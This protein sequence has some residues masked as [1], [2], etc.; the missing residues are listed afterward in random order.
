MVE[1][2]HD[3]FDPVRFLS[4]VNVENLIERNKARSENEVNQIKEP[5][6]MCNNHNTSG[7]TLNDQTFICKSCFREVSYIRFPEK[8]EGLERE[9]LVQLAARQRAL[10]SLIE[11]CW[12]GK[13]SGVLSFFGWLSLV[14]LLVQFSYIILP[15]GF[16]ILYALAQSQHEKKIG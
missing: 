1:T 10:G 5:C 16:F 6:I 4:N 8:Y 14:L 13:M 15:I 7:L 3:S 12:F 2:W 11:S 9:Y